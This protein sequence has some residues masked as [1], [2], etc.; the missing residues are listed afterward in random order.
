MLREG[1]FF[2]DSGE[3]SGEG[4]SD[5]ENNLTHCALNT[6]ENESNFMFLS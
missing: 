3:W 4:F 6:H 5:R 2:E 1:R